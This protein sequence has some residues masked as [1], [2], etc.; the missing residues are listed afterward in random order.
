[1]QG[2]LRKKTKIALDYTLCGDGNGQDPRECCACM[3]ACEP[4]VFLLHQTL[5]T[6]EKNP[7]DPQIWR[8]SPL[9]LSLCTQ[10]MKCADVCPVGAITLG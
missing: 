3:Q 4:A 5:D 1:M 8:I 6:N 2:F 9:W 7:L 10:C